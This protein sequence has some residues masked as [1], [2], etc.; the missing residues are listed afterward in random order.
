MSNNT[1]HLNFISAAETSKGKPV[2]LGSCRAQALT[3]IAFGIKFNS[4]DA[5]LEYDDELC[6]FA[7]TSK[8]GEQP[9]P[10]HLVFY[11]NHDTFDESIRIARWRRPLRLGYD[12]IVHVTG[13]IVPDI[14]ER[15]VLAAFFFRKKGERINAHFGDMRS[16]SF[17]IL[18]WEEEVIASFEFS[19]NGERKTAFIIGEL[20]KKDDQWVFSP[21]GQARTGWLPSLLRKFE[22]DYN[23]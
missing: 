10:N 11:N 14:V 9:E 22:L 4:L 12:D 3:Q 7:I 21:S 23:W 8:G 2:V 18:N 17:D 19:G 20:C 15:I 5:E 13:D 6:A 1:Q 16:I